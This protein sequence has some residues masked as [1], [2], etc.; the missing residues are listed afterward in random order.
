M[1]KFYC[2]K[3]HIVI[4]VILTL[5]GLTKT[6]SVIAH[7]SQSIDPQLFHRCVL[8]EFSKKAYA[9]YQ[10]KCDLPP[11]QAAEHVSKRFLP[12]ILI[13]LIVTL[14]HGI[15]FVVV[16]CR[17]KESI[18]HTYDLGI[19]DLLMKVW[20]HSWLSLKSTLN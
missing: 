10:I 18:D 1:N 5:A 4:V 7:E 16:G 6:V 13:L 15:F 8:N 9:H 11:E 20:L 3:T 2:S 17:Q 19:M 12:D 14:S